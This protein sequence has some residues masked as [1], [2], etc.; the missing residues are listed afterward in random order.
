MRDRFLTGL[1]GYPIAHSAAP[2]MHE[3]AAAALGVRC[4]Y[5]LIEVKGAGRNDLRAMLEGIRRLGFAGVNVTFPYKEAVV[6]LIDSL[7][8]DARAIAAVNTIVADGARLV[9]HNTDATGFVRAITPLLASTPRG[10]I[11]LIGAG[12]VGKAIAFALAGLGVGELRIF[13]ADAAKVARLAGQLAG[14]HAVRGVAS[15]EAAVDGATGVVNATPVGMLPNRDSPVPQSLLHPSM[16]VADAVYTPLWTPLL[17]AAKAKGSK[18]LTGRDLAIYAAA[19]AFELFT[20][21]MP[22]TDVM[23]NA[24]DAVMAARYSAPA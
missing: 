18:V 1:I 19:D 11:A 16:W 22:S 21:M 7:A 12:G 2:A 6:D 10:P 9:G 5:Q 23:A 4:H 17:L 8:P 24:F 20:T 14:R 15:V 3:K 13:D